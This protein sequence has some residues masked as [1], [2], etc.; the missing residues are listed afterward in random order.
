MVIYD[1]HL[2][3]VSCFVCV[4][5]CACMCVCVCVCVCVCLSV[6]VCVCV[7]VSVC[8]SVSVRACVC[9]FVRTCVRVCACMRVTYFLYSLRENSSEANAVDTPPGMVSVARCDFHG[10]QSRN[11]L[12]SCTEVYRFIRMCLVL[13][14]VLV[15]AFA[16]E[17]AA[18]K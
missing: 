1:H 11:R 6:C 13:V 2:S 18:G 10:I 8:V 16:T 7:C 4:C 14:C 12:I 3:M 15:I 5:V 9:V 17:I